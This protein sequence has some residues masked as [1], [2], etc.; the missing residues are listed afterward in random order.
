MAGRLTVS[1]LDDH[2]TDYLRLRRAL[3]FTLERHGL[4]LPQPV[5]DLE[6]AGATTVTSKLAIAWARLP[7]S[8]QPRHWAARLS[9]ARGFAAYR[10]RSTPPPRFRRRTC[11]PSAIAGQPRTCG[12]PLTSSDC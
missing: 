9:I 12:R 6:A 11:S 3:G 2:V 5:A 10:R 4:V 8:A 1:A 7:V